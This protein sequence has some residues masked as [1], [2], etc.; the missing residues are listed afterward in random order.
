MRRSKAVKEGSRADF[1]WRGHEF[2]LLEKDI[3]EVGAVNRH[4]AH[5]AS[6]I[7]DGLVVGGSGRPLSRESVALQA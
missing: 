6:L 3:A 4:V 5:G 7:F 2:P 1:S